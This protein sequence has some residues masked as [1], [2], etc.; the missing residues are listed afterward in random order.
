MYIDP[1]GELW[2]KNDTPDG[3][4]IP[5][6]WVV[7]C[8]EGQTC[9]EAV[10]HNYRAGVR[11]YG[12]NDSKDIIEY[13]ANAD[14]MVDVR[15]LSQHHNAEFIVAN[16]QAHPEEFLSTASARDLFNVAK[17][18]SETFAGDEKLVFTAGSESN[19]KPAT[20]CQGPGRPCHAGHKGHD[21][22]LRYMGS[23]GK[24]VQGNTA[25]Q[26]ADVNRTNWLIN[27]FRIKGLPNSYTGD[28]SRFGRQ[29]KSPKA[30]DKRE[31]IHRHHLH[32]GL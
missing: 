1:S 21:I 27:A 7:K 4:D 19:G 28:E 30:I 17:S 5:Y 2:I 20:G 13:A 31:Y 11:V 25:Y 12:S 10:A 6:L 22:D 23:N 26:V 18:Y 3:K 16:G 29:D 32:A 15:R 24:P 14:G 8:S 9:Y